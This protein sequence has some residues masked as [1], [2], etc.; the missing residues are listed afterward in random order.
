[1][2]GRRELTK[3]ANRAAI[4]D[5]A[6]EV[7]AEQGYEAASVRDIIR[8]TDLASGTFY[9][10]FPDKDAIFLA[11]IEETSEEARRRV[12]DARRSATTASEFVEGGYRAFFEFIVEEP[13]R[14]AFMRRNLETMSNRFGET[15]LPAGTEE[16]A[17]DLRAA[18]DAGHLPP[19]DVDYCAH[20]MVAV[21]LEL[22]ARLAERTPPDVEGATRFA[23][24]LFLGALA[25]SVR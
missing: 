22:G 4:L 1:M 3:A 8:H 24:E 20:A 25:T 17:D 14:F 12:R 23:A 6:R 2:I 7:F 15:V 10:Y 16:L 5:A 19:V 21:G 18:I 11:L 13:E 9:N